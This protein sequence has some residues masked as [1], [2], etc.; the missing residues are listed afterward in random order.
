MYL[1]ASLGGAYKTE[2]EK[3]IKARKAA[4]ITNQSSIIYQ[5][6]YGGGYVT[7]VQGTKGTVMVMSGYVS[8]YN[9]D[10]FTKVSD[11]TNYAYY[12]SNDVDLN[13]T[14]E[15]ANIG[16]GIPV[17]DKPSG[18]YTSSVTVNVKPSNRV[19]HFGLYDRRQ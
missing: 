7:K 5:G 11:G 10:G 14:L 4:G 13:A 8:G 12:V 19:D 15:N 1:L 9:V 2:L 16:S 17:V 3:M 6:E 18:S